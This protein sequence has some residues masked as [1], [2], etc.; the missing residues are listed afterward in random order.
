[1]GGA[2]KNSLLSIKEKQKVAAGGD[3]TP[4]TGYF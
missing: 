3:L 4:V 2:V 1:M